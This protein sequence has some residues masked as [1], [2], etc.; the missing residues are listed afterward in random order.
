MKTLVLMRHATS[1]W[2]SPGLPDHDRPLN[3][4]GRQ[5]A[6]RMGRRLVERGI[7]PDLII[8]STAER[9]RSTAALV[10]AEL[11]TPAR[12]VV[13]DERLYAASVETML[14]VIRSLDD[15]L[16]SAMLVGHNPEMTELATRFSRTAEAMPTAAIAVFTFDA[17]SWADVRTATN[18]GNLAVPPITMTFDAPRGA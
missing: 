1:S 3:E 18:A 12:R 6:P 8:S 7:D 2:D 9:A 15:R 5:D 13:T 14:R 17:A 10:A 16:S 4:R 11:G